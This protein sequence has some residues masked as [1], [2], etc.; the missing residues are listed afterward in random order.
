MIPRIREEW[1]YR[2]DYKNS[3]SSQVGNGGNQIEVGMNDYLSD[4]TAMEKILLCI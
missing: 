3:S 1:Y 4:T 2:N